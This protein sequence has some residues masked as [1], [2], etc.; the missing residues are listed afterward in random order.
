MVK[1]TS[2]PLVRVGNSRGIRLPARLIAKHHLEHG[3]TLEERGDEIVLLPKSA[4]KKLSWEETAKEMAASDED[5]S[6]WEGM[7]DGW[8]DE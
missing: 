4:P 6:A 7:R 3:M 1:A 2:V 8:E 5:W